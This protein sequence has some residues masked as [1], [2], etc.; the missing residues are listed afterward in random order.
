MGCT[1]STPSKITFTSDTSDV[2]GKGRFGLVIKGRYNDEDVAIKIIDRSEDSKNELE[3]HRKL[4]HPN[5]VKLIAVKHASSQVCLVLELMEQD[6][7]AD[8][9]KKR[10]SSLDW[11]RSRLII[12]GIVAGVHYLHTQG[13]LHRDLKLENILLTPGYKA[14]IADFGISIK[15]PHSEHIKLLGTP[16]YMAPEHINIY[17]KRKRGVSEYSYTTKTDLYALGILILAVIRLER[18]LKKLES[19]D[20]KMLFLSILMKQGT[21]EVPSETPE[22]LALVIN[23]CIS[24]DPID[25][26]EAQEI[27]SMFSENTT[28]F[29]RK[30]VV[31]LELELDSGSTHAWPAKQETMR[32][33]RIPY[34]YPRYFEEKKQAHAVLDDRACF[35]AS[36]S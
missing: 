9:I 11:P 27:I 19:L 4:N 35:V 26:P 5:I 29:D 23:R 22:A 30:H 36:P 13:V 33:N 1:S 2:L 14:K 31:N 32:R 18:P 21:D 10:S 8:L 6:D 20:T 12:E 15:Q 16:R 7:L 28:F 34:A 25:R 17:L 3:I 24:H